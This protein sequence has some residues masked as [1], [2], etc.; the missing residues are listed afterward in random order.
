MY[1]YGTTAGTKYI[2]LT[3]DIALGAYLKIGQNSVSQTVTID[4]NGHTL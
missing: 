4:M 2:R 1:N 3:A